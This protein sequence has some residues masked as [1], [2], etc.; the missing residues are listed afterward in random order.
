MGIEEN[1]RESA[2]RLFYERVFSCP[3]S[4][5]TKDA[6]VSQGILFHYFGTKDELIA[7][8]YAE[9]VEG[10]YA[11]AATAFASGVEDPDGF[12]KTLK[13]SWLR[14]VDWCLDHWVEF[15]YMR[16]FEES[17]RA[18]AGVVPE[19]VVRFLDEQIERG[20]SL[21]AVRSFDDAYLVAVGTAVTAATV[22]HLHAHPAKRGDEGFMEQAWRIYWQPKEC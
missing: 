5:I 13:R 4:A 16:M 1:I 15:S 10:Y 2:Y 7:D 8:L 3:T 11:E 6:G 14:Q 12:V 21:G 19:K 22:R 9:A 18:A 20:R 17:E